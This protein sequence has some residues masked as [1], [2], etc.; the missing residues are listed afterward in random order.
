MS[1][2]A[3][4][5]L[6]IVVLLVGIGAFLWTRSSGMESA[7]AP[8]PAKPLDQELISKAQE[9]CWFNVKSLFPR[10]SPGHDWGGVSSTGV[11]TERLGDLIIVSGAFV[12]SVK[13]DR[14][15]GCALFEYTEGSPVVMT[16]KT[17]SSPFRPETLVPLG[18]TSEGR[19][20]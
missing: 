5:A 4:A 20:Q 11:R 10:L 14:F 3:V 2:R 1:S 15:Y 7:G 8:G 9:H 19:K 17:A 13:D 6:V 16:A 18:F 12:P